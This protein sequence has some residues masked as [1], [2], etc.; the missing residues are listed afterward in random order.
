MIRKGIVEDVSQCSPCA[1]GQPIIANHRCQCLVT[2]NSNAT[3]NFIDKTVSWAKD[4]PYLAI[5]LAIS[6]Y[7]AFFKKD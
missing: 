5:G 6:A 2:Q 4:N 7:V 3:P 1:N